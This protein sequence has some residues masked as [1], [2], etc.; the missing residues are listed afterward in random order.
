MGNLYYNEIYKETGEKKMN[1]INQNN[2]EQRRDK[3]RKRYKGGNMDNVEFIPAKE[4]PKLFDSDNDMKVVVY[5]RVSTLNSQQTSSQVMQEEYYAD[6]VSRQERLIYKGGQTTTRNI[7][8]A[9]GS[10]A[11]V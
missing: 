5:A 3:I 10:F 8:T 9:N 4:T 11:T 6:F 2:D 1:I 7:L